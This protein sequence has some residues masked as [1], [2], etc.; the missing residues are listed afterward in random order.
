[1]VFEDIMSKE[2][3]DIDYNTNEYLNLGASYLE[4]PEQDYTTD[5]EIIDTS[6][7]DNDIWK[8]EDSEQSVYIPLE[9]DSNDAEQERVEDVVLEARF[10]AKKIKELIDSK[11]QV[12]DKKEGKNMDIKDPWGCNIETYKQCAEEIKQCLEMLIDNNSKKGI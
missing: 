8:D 7:E 12:I 4:I 10:V 3:G 2:L 5:I 9:E 6:D 1:M 11:Y